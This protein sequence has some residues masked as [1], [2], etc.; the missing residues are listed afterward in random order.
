MRITKAIKELNQ[1]KPINIAAVNCGNVLGYE[2]PNSLFCGNCDNP[3]H[4]KMK[5]CAKCR[6]ILQYKKDKI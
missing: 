2:N 3:V 1:H 5:I 6:S 4:K